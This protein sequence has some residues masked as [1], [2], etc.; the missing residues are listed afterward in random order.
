[1]PAS[2]ILPAEYLELPQLRNESQLGLVLTVQKCISHPHSWEHITVWSIWCRWTLCRS[3]LWQGWLDGWMERDGWALS[4][5]YRRPVSM[6]NPGRHRLAT[7]VFTWLSYTWGFFG[8]KPVFTSMLFP[9][10]LGGTVVWPSWLP[11]LDH[12]FLWAPKWEIALIYTSVEVCGFALEVW[13]E[14]ILSTHS[15]VHNE[16]NDSVPTAPWNVLLVLVNRK[17]VS[18]ESQSENWLKKR[19]NPF[20][21]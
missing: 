6:H 11:V 8:K 16:C 9:H 13:L 15:Q 1:M 14:L 20:F 5:G 10:V 19:Q 4:L 3:S 21:S 7:S 18:I 12:I 2:W 17:F